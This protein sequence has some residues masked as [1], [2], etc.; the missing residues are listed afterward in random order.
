MTRVVLVDDHA[1][2]RRGMRDALADEG[3]QV[4]AEAS[5]WDE[6]EPLLRR[7][8]LADAAA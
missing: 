2:I 1:L 8:G 5:C 3:L 4:V 7:R 6:L